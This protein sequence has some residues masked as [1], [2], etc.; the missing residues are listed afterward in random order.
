MTQA[1]RLTGKRALVTG[2]GT[3][4][5]REVALEFARQGADV[6]LHYSHSDS[7]AASAVQ[8]IQ[9][10]GRKAAA[11]AADFGKLQDAVGLVERAIDFHGGLDIVVNNAGITF[12]RPFDEITPEQFD[13]LVNVNVRAQFFITQAAAR[14]MSANAGGAICNISSIH[15][16][17][18]APEY[19]LYAA[20]KGAIIAYTRAAAVELACRGVR[21]NCVAP[22][23]VT[24]ENYANAIPGYD[25]E[26][27]KRD[28]ARRIPVA[29]QGIPLDIARLVAFLCSD[30][31]S[32]IVG[33]T[34]VAD[35]GTVALSS[36]T[37]DF[38]ARSTSRWGAGYVPGV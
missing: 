29:R 36:L 21:L 9:H 2:S 13:L 26:Q 1:D 16:L 15:G 10:L 37:T 12:T 4:I 8:E 19:A 38:R 23:W 27:E 6:A 20:T 7:G 17:Q 22:G 3:G 34:I 35:G 14:L 31:A 28:A 32:F 25:P 24:V 30:D 33:E 11:F 18:G 5:G